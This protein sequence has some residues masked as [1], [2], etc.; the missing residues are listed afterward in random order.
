MSQLLEDKGLQKEIVRVARKQKFKRFLRNTGIIL[1]A[2][3]LLISAMYI[4]ISENEKEKNQAKLDEKEAEIT[5]L[6]DENQRLIDEAIVVNPI[7][8]KIELDIIQSEIDSIGELASIEYLFTD[9]AVYSDSK[10]LKKWKIPVTEKSFA[11]KWDGVIKAGIELE[12]VSVEAGEDEKSI[13]IFLPKA[14]ILSYEVNQDTYEV[15]YEKDNIFNNLTIKDK[16]GLDKKTEEAMKE[17]AIENG[18]LEKA[19]ANAEDILFRLVNSLPGV[20]D[21][22]TIVFTT[23][24]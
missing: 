17:R 12:Q 4:I 2:I 13:V 7:A 8:P 14:K 11:V 15:V 22:Y 21:N 19:Q 20:K 16:V 1:I 23:I 10:H 18:L 6:I 9:C 24:S 5:R 3:I